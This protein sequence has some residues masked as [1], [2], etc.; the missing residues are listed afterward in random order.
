MVICKHIFT[1]QGT[2]VDLFYCGDV[3]YRRMEFSK[4]VC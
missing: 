3:I 2:V 4:F 1:S